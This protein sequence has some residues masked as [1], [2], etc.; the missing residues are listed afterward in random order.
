M[1]VDHRIRDEFVWNEPITRKLGKEEMK[2]WLCLSLFAGL[3]HFQTIS[4]N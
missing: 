3:L 4:K 1:F 2:D